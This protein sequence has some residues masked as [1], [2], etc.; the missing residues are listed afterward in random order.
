MFLASL[1]GTRPRRPRRPRRTHQRVAPLTR[2][3]T[4]GRARRPEPRGEVNAA[5]LLE[6]LARAPDGRALRS[7]GEAGHDSRDATGA[8]LLR[9]EHMKDAGRAHTALHG[10]P[11]ARARSILRCA[12]GSWRIKNA[13]L[14]FVAESVAATEKRPPLDHSNIR[15]VTHADGIFVA[16]RMTFAAQLPRSFRG[17]ARGSWRPGGSWS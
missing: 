7:E 6:S 15:G 2:K 5:G 8:K 3:R 16:S 17:G 11:T 14:F 9:R 12:F 10:A 1:G 13:C 4:G